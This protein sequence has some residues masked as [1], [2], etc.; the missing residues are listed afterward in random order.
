MGYLM[1]FCLQIVCNYGVA[2]ILFTL[3]TKLVLLPLSIWL[4]KNSIK[5]IKL[6]PELN[7]IRARNMG[8]TQQALD[9]QNKLYKQENYKPLA[10]ILPMLI[11]ILIVIG[12]ISVVNHPLQHLLHI[13]GNTIRLLIDKTAEFLAISAPEAVGQ[14][15]VVRLIQSPAYYEAFN[16]LSS[17]SAMAAVDAIRTLNMH[18]G[19]MMLANTPQLTN[20]ALWLSGEN[21][22]PLAS[23]A[24]AFLLSF[25]QNTI[26]ILQKEAGWFNRWGMAIFLSLFS[27]YFGATVPTGVAI[28]WVFSNLF[29]I[30]VMLI[31]YWLIPPK[32]YI[33]YTA[34]EESKRVLARSKA[35]HAKDAITLEQKKR[36]HADYKRFCNPAEPMRL[37]FYSEKSGFYKYFAAI[38]DL[39]I[40]KSDIVVHYITS[41]PDD[42]VFAYE[43]SQFIPYFMD[44]HQLIL[45]F[46]KADAD[47]MIMTMPDLQQFHLKRSY[48]R[49]D[50]E[51]VYIYHGMIV[52]LQTVRKGATQYYDTLLCT[53]ETQVR[54]EKKIE[55]FYQWKPRKTI[56]CGYPLLDEMILQYESMAHKPDDAQKSILIAPSYQ[57]GNILDCCVLDLVDTLR[58]CGYD[59][60]I[61]PHPQYLK[62]FPD[63]FAQLCEACEPYLGDDFRI[64][65][66]FSSN[67]TVY[68]ADL[69]IT[70]WSSI[71]YEYAFTT[72]KPVLFIDTPMKIINPDY[73]ECEIDNPPE[74][75]LRSVIGCSVRPENVSAE[76]GVK[77]QTMLENSKAYS[78]IIADA[79][80]ENICNLGHAAEVAADYIIERICDKETNK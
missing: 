37:I 6:Q 41:D 9:E 34:L 25:A 58:A 10:G 44:E 19:S 2:I 61:R 51:Y 48:I 66:D 29:A 78:Q 5:M 54:Q 23:C 20:A 80:A 68:S 8:N 50:M 76:A 62:L 45:A 13:D 26:N 24:S 67:E 11:Q 18:M 75:Y 64:Q 53:G 28:Y 31:T 1:R 46:M 12:L 56:A 74:I 30:L 55:S 35:A 71:A 77:I 57:E 32:R 42:Q 39:V 22:M 72:L 60:T 36:S 27:L 7:M 70:D 63:R 14:L 49:K 21:L 40:K 33:D 52:G 47:M 3:V 79:R 16:S 59:V 69:V 43:S 38:I 17:Q 73:A 65:T 15:D 4:H